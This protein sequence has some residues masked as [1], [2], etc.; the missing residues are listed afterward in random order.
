MEGVSLPAFGGEPERLLADAEELGR[1]GQVQPGF[2]AVCGR[3][4]HRDAMVGA[5][6][7]PT[8]AGPTIAMTREEL[9]AVQ[10]ARNEIV[11]G[12][13]HQQ[14]NGGDYVGRG[15]VALAASSSWQT[16]L[17]VDATHPMNDENDL[18]RV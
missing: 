2:D 5:Q 15:A 16:N 13:A 10:N 11:I 12:D 1:P 18:G 8:L 14:P 3:A 6:R 4:P 9:V 7:R 17:G